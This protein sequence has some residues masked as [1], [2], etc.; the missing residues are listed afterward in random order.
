MQL[1]GLQY[2]LSPIAIKSMDEIVQQM[3]SAPQQPEIAFDAVDTG[4]AKYTFYEKGALQVLLA[5]PDGNNLQ[6]IMRLNDRHLNRQQESF[7]A[8][9]FTS[10]K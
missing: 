9:H 4:S 7:L 10:I 1:H 6:A 3:R 5:T 2:D 8:R